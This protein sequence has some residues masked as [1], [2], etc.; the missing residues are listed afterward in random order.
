MGIF[1]KAWEYLRKRGSIL[2]S[3][4]IFAKA[5]EYFW[6][7]GNIYDVGRLRERMDHYASRTATDR[8][9]SEIRKMKRFVLSVLIIKGTIQ[10]DLYCVRMDGRLLL[11]RGFI[12]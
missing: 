1:A 3:V 2:D 10:R 11:T 5:W 9:E 4:G 7:R 6:Q 8:R 12:F